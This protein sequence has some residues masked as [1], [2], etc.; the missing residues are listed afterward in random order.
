M[1]AGAGRTLRTVRA[2]GV[3]VAFL[4]VAVLVST[5]VGAAGLDPWATVA[6]LLDRLPLVHLSSGLSPLDRAVLFD[7]RLP[8]IVLGA[9]VGGLLAVSGA[10]YQGVFRN[11]LVDSGL[12]GA[13]AGAGL[14]ATV[15]IVYLGGTGQAAVPVAAFVGSLAG[16]AVAY[17]AGASGGPG[18][19]TL[20]LAGLAVG[21]FLTAVQTYLLQ[22]SSQDLQQVYSWLLGSLADAGWHQVLVVLPYAAVSTAVVLLHGRHLDVLAV[23][24]EEARSLGLRPGWIRLA[25]VAACALAA[26]TAVA[27]SGLIGFVGIIVPHA[28]RRL[29]GTSYRVVLPLSLLVGAGFLVLADTLARTVIAPAE[30]PI[31]VVTALIGSPVFVWILRTTRTVRT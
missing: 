28:V 1:S 2:Y 20:L 31:G 21:M 8:R 6:A 25:V 23:G 11:A 16:V 24:D 3:A 27:V 4:L 19:A 18:T 9:L 12:L 10:G 22:R 30:L 14:G 26:A 13:S 7:I 17:L 15:A 29:A 5:V